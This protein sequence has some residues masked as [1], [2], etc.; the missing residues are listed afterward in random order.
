MS[1]FEAT[2][3]N[4]I[5]LNQA[6]TQSRNVFVNKIEA[7]LEDQYM[8]YWHNDVSTSDKSGSNKNTDNVSLRY[9]LK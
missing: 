2:G 8:Q 1:I 3:L 9:I 6:T 5:W 4:N 7:I